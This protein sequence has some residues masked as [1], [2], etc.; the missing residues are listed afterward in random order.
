MRGH[1]YYLLQLG[2][3]TARAENSENMCLEVSEA[4][5]AG[6][7]ELC[8]AL[9]FLQSEILALQL[10]GRKN[11]RDT[12]FRA[13]ISPFI[14]CSTCFSILDWVIPS[15]NTKNSMVYFYVYKLTGNF[16]FFR[17]YAS[18]TKELIKAHWTNF[19]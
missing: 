15:K 9:K 18:C 2:N 14:L 12:F 7:R 3:F 16:F 1:S 10:Y 4:S 6:I 8:F 13:L 19:K 5:D 17:R 11:F